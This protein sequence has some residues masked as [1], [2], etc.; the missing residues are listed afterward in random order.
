MKT[1]FW[2]IC[3]TIF[4]KT[5]FE[6]ILDSWH[7]RTPTVRSAQPA[8][9]ETSTS[10]DAAGASKPA[11]DETRSRTSTR[12]VQLVTP[13]NTQTFFCWK[14][15]NDWNVWKFTNLTKIFFSFSFLFFH[16]QIVDHFLR[17][18]RIVSAHER[19]CNCIYFK[20]SLALK[21]FLSTWKLFPALQGNWWTKLSSHR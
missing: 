15:E 14:M 13:P 8:H 9:D 4:T 1:N 6:N 20:C 17:W 2:L 21:P 7:A 5:L 10:D 16:L 12:W 3:V 19:I 18:T 11:N